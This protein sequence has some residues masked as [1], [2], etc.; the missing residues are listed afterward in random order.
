MASPPPFDCGRMWSNVKLRYGNGLRQPVQRPLCDTNSARRFAAEL[1][2]LRPALPGYA[3]RG[4]A[5][6]LARASSRSWNQVTLI[7]A[8]ADMS[9]GRSSSA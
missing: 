1:Y 4:Q 8:K 7:S 9:S 5:G 3:P 2:T 6:T